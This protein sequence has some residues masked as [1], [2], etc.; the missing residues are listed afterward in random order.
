MLSQYYKKM[1]FYDCFGSTEAPAQGVQLFSGKPG[2]AYLLTNVIPEIAKPEDVMKARKGNSV[3]VDSILWP[4]WRAGMRGG[5]IINRPGESLPLIRYPT[6]DIIEVIDPA[7]DHAIKLDHSDFSFTLPIIKYLGRS[8]DL[9]DF[10]LSDEKGDFLGGRI[11]SSVVSEHLLK[12]PNIR[13]WEFYNVNTVPGKLVF[14]IIP[15]TPVDDPDAFMAKILKSLNAV[16][17]FLSV[18]LMLDL[19]KV[20]VTKPSAYRLVEEGTD[21]R[22]KS[23]RSLGQL[24]P[25][26]VMSVADDA[27]LN[28]VIKEKIEAL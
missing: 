5:L 10:E 12:V 3:K 6:G 9:V 2:F 19:V 20:I 28:A 14:I 16:G 11:Y 26:R 18:G 4:E 24:K 7:Y 17:T 25:R 13:W 15:E 27:A 21:R 1:K 23:G 22:V 8:V